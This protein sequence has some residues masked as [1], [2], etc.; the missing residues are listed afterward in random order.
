MS[1]QKLSRT[2]RTNKKRVNKS[3]NKHS[4]LTKGLQIGGIIIGILVIIITILCFY[5]AATAPKVTNA[6]LTGTSQSNILDSKDNVIWTS[7]SEKREIAQQDEYPK[8]LKDA[9]VAIEDRRF[10]Q[11][12]GVD[13]RRIFGAAMANFTGSSLGLQGGST[14]TQQLVKQTAFSSAITDQTFKRKVQEAWIAMRIEKQYSK[15]Q[16]LTLYMN[17]VYMGSGAY[18]MKTAANF[19]YN[20]DMKDLTM[21][22]VALIAGLPQSPSGYDPY[23]NPS[24]AKYRRNQVLD[25]M[26]EYGSIT[27][28]EASQYKATP[29]DDGLVTDHTEQNNEAE[30]AK[31]DDSYIT[32][33][34]AQVKAAKYNIHQDG[35]TIK[36]NL[37]PD[38]QSKA[39]DVVNSSANNKYG[40]SYPDDE[41]QAAVTITDPQSGNVIA[42]IGGR[43]QDTLQGLNLA[44]STQ[45]SGGSTVKPLIDYAPAIEN[46]NW[47]T[48]RALDDSSSFKYSGTDLAAG[49]AGMTNSQPY[50]KKTGQPY[51]SMRNALTRSLNVPALHTLEGQSP[52]SATEHDEYVGHAKAS[53]FLKKLG[54]TPKLSGSSAIGFNVSTEQEAAA[55]SAFANGGI[56]YKPSYVKTITTQ[57]G[58]VKSMDSK[59]QRAMK[60]STAFMMND[61][62]KS[63]ISATGTWSLGFSQYQTDDYVQGAKSGTVAYPADSDYPSSA[64]Q[65]LW[66]TGFTKSA[67]ISVWTGYNEPMSVS[68]PLDGLSGPTA[69]LPNEIYNTLM[70]YVMTHDNRDGSDWNKPSSVRKV[71]KNGQTEYEVAGEDFNDPFSNRL[72]RIASNSNSQSSTTI[73]SS[74][75]IY[76]SISSGSSQTPNANTNVVTPS[77][78]IPGSN[79]G[80]RSTGGNNAGASGGN[81]TPDPK[82]N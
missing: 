58:I 6:Q 42:Q 65:D 19:Y 9:V 52:I 34:L 60:D 33:V 2:K 11:H 15:A 49:D 31:V 13:I 39:Y 41:V 46:F 3:H 82:S 35:L 29:I 24:G 61:M 72:P 45:R 62:L 10:Y 25:A 21:P 17:K 66:F 50:S 63:V 74:S 16:I 26:A 4:R 59:G 23:S 77:T 37:D 73:A 40:I 18:G 54:M 51:V 78:T 75:T 8:D 68:K 55:F 43:N 64:A 27:R 81:T 7:G 56:Y 32:S 1:G 71:T 14:L 76:S 44:T 28:D 69:H 30:T 38:V 70:K 36:T 20:K 80:G 22:Q 67:A 53:D 12:G 79:Q 5:W 48:Y 47:P 57:D